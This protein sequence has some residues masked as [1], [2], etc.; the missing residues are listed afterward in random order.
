MLDFVLNMYKINMLQQFLQVNIATQ[1]KD[2]LYGIG[3][4]QYTT[5]SSISPKHLAK[6]IT[7]QY[8]SKIF[9]KQQYLYVILE[10]SVYNTG[11]P[12]LKVKGKSTIL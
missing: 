10:Q 6:L 5:S 12:L 2:N 11:I 9:L 3:S 4:C 7:I 1:I 8:A